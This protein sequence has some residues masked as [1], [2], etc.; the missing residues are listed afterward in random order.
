MFTSANILDALIFFNLI[1]INAISVYNY[2]SVADIQGES[3]LAV[4]IQ[5]ALIYLPVFYALLRFVRWLNSCSKT[6]P[7]NNNHQVN[8]HQRDEIN[9]EEVRE[10]DRQQY[11]DSVNLMDG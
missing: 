4:G 7:Q 6:H 9:L 11:V 10:R 1:L 3:H 8:E 5:L 2:Y